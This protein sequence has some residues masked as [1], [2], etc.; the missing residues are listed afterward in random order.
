MGTTVTLTLIDLSIF[1]QRLAPAYSR[2][3]DSSDT[4]GLV[5]LTKSAVADYTVA[6]GNVPDLPSL[7]V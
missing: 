5:A 2:Y 3:A 4:S 1:D 7:K 6:A